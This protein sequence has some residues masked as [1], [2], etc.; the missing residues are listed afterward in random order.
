M[1]AGV[2]DGF[3]QVGAFREVSGFRDHQ[4]LA[5]RIRHEGG[6]LLG[7]IIA[8]L[9]QANDPSS[10]GKSERGRLVGQERRIFSEL[11]SAQFGEPERVLVFSQHGADGLLR[12]LGDEAGVGSIEE[13]KPQ[14]WQEVVKLARK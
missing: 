2:G 13:E 10:P 11:P 12:Q 4:R 1:L 7:Q 14:L 5:Y 6:E 9:T 8:Y 3:H